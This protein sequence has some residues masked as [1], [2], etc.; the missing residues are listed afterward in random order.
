MDFRTT[1]NCFSDIKKWFIM[2]NASILKYLNT[3]QILRGGFSDFHVRVQHI[4]TH[5]CIRCYALRWV[6]AAVGGIRN[7]QPSLVQVRRVFENK[8]DRKV[9]FSVFLHEM[10]LKI[11]KRTRKVEG[12]SVGHS[13]RSNVFTGKNGAAVLFLCNKTCHQDLRKLCR[14]LN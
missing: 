3:F 2:S 7:Y 14:V 4:Q 6:V 12:S 11:W 8:T 1:L 5:F 10:S 9:H 13:R